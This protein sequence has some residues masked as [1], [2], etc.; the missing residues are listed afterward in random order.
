MSP[1]ELQKLLARELKSIPDPE[2]RAAIESMLVPPYEERRSS[3]HF[4]GTWSCWVVAR[5]D[6]ADWVFVYCRSYFLGNWGCLVG[7]ESDL[8]MDSQW[9]G[10]LDDAFYSFVWYRPGR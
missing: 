6:S 3:M 2:R 8:G 10:S 5:D 4:D 1:V 9:F 7:S